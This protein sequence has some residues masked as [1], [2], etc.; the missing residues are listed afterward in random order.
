M[1]LFNFVVSRLAQRKRAGLI[2]QSFFYRNY[3]RPLFLMIK[4][5]LSV[6]SSLLML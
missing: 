2:I 5:K 3:P 4:I 1:W 6:L